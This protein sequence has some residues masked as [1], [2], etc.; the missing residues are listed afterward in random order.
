MKDRSISWATG[1]CL[2]GAVVLTAPPCV[3][4]ADGFGAN[5]LAFLTD[6]NLAYVLLLLG[7]YGI[8]LEALHPGSA[9]PGIVGAICLVLA[10]AALNS[11]PVNYAGLA[12]LLVG[13]ALMIG[14][15]FAPTFGVL[16]VSGFAAFVAGS[17]YLI[18]ESGAGV[19]LAVL[20]PAAVLSALFLVFVVGMALKAR[21][22]PVV[23][24][25]E[26]LVG[27]VGIMLEDAEREGYARVHG[28]IWRVRAAAPLKRG[29]R[30]RVTAVDGLT[31]AVER[32]QS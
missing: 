32:E 27:S 15:A 14:E 29:D 11:L 20:L 23:S 26:E 6:P 2:L 17:L 16:G 13:I 19:K 30:V 28:E 12:L 7:L 1:R 8:L 24:G 18:D 25:R 21:R 9:V 10:I 4:E 31:L 5:L 3:G 22:R